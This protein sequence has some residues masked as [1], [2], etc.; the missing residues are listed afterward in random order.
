VAKRG[1]PRAVKAQQPRVRHGDTAVGRG[2]SVQPDGLMIVLNLLYFGVVAPSA[3]AI[4]ACMPKG[5]ALKGVA[6]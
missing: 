5:D 1:N 4:A 3:S 6:S 2:W